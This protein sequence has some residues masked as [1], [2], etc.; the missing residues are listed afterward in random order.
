[1]RGGDPGGDTI[2]GHIR[3]LLIHEQRGISPTFAD[4]AGV[5]PLF[6]DTLELAEEV[7]LG[8]LAGVAPFGVEQAM[9]E[10]E[11]QRGGA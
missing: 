3:Q 10:M 2:A 8:L 5:E 11:E 1:M 7:E 9:G 4:Q 6:S